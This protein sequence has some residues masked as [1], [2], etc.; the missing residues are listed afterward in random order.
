MPKS[1]QQPQA[2]AATPTTTRAPGK[3]VT[4]L[5]VH[6][7]RERLAEIQSIVKAITST[8]QPTNPLLNMVYVE[9]L[10]DG[11][12]RIVATDTEQSFTT[13]VDAVVDRPGKALIHG[14]KFAML[15]SVLPEGVIELRECGQRIEV[16]GGDMTL[17]LVTMPVEDFPLPTT[18]A[19]FEGE[20]RTIKV[21][22]ARLLEALLFTV[23]IVCTDDNR[24]GINGLHMEWQGEQLRL[25]SSDGHRLSYAGVDVLFRS[26]SASPI[27]ERVLLPRKAL[28]QITNL[29]SRNSSLEV[30]LRFGGHSA[31]LSLER[32]VFRFRLIEGEFPD[33]H[34][35]VPSSFS[36]IISTDLPR[37]H[38][39]FKRIHAMRVDAT[40]VEVNLNVSEG[41]I[42]AKGQDANHNVVE[43]RGVIK[44]EKAGAPPALR[45][46]LNAKYMGECLSL[47]DGAT[48][49]IACSD[50]LSPVR[51][52]DE[53][54]D[55]IM[56]VMPMR[57]G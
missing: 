39:M 25:V 45:I 18:A 41:T 35:V 2:A 1:R 10:E 6:V 15:A 27:G 44:S 17:A 37:L 34:R 46:G 53:K 56:I 3:E 9:A 31:S 28:A 57:L 32:S 14:D 36:F 47:L 23:P 48:V 54:P 19:P 40:P 38:M 13:D 20:P 33:Y 22:A 29:L 12:L 24:Y 50:P 30:A 51:L 49:T 21:R 5:H 16:V 26:S 55:R 8:H 52:T 42:T 7:A 4:G 43:D 11:R